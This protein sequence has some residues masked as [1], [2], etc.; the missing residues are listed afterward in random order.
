MARS[1]HAGL[2]H[3]RFGP[4]ELIAAR[5]RL[6]Q[7]GEEVAVPKKSYDLLVHLVRHRDRVVPRAEILEVCWPDVVVSE[8]AFASVVRDLRRALGETGHAS[9]FVSTIRGRGLRFVHPV[10]E[11]SGAEDPTAGA[12]WVEAA[13]HFERALRAL[14]LIDQSRGGREAPGPG[15][16]PRERAELI[17]ALAR[18]QW[19][20][21]APAEAREA[22]LDAARAARSSGDAELLARAALGFA[23]RTDATLGVN[24]ESVELLNEALVALGTSDSLLRAEVLAR[25]GTE[26]YYD[27][28]PDASKRNASDGL[29]MAERLG[30]DATTAYAATAC[31]FTLQRPEIAPQERSAFCDRAL[32]LCGQDPPSDVLALALQEKLVDA[33]EAGDRSTFDGAF[34]RYEAV[35]ETLG[36]PFFHWMLGLFRGNRALLAGD[37]RAAEKL[38]EETAALGLRIGSP[39]ATAAFSGQLFALRQQQRRLP[40][41]EASL[42]KMVENGAPP[43]FRVGLVATQAAGAS[44]ERARSGIDEIFGDGLRDFP[45]DM[46][47]L[48]TLGA[49][50]PAV[51]AVGS[52]DR[53]RQMVE[54]LQPFGGRMIV[55][56]YGAA[57]LG[58]VD[59]HLARLHQSLHDAPKARDH[60]DKAR[61]LH[62]RMKTR[63]WDGP[64]TENPR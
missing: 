37:F 24:Q 9:R 34:H 3:W 49:L 21:G 52:Q 53:V 41:L 31:H 19:A 29:A 16:Q 6:L 43:I 28:D 2:D 14:D 63:L 23:G 42:A 7:A 35:V 54:L 47:W 39:N 15:R 55:V 12:S 57:T 27:P 64:S 20:S 10:Q 1:G 45:R 13:T 8:A 18:A 60:F 32:E 59:H 62:A 58:A 40:E 26:L 38:A 30:D 36:Q 51:A 4:F 22:F 50:A 33:F 11:V 46:N 61:A 48:A 44:P 56:G 5:G 25:L 17:V